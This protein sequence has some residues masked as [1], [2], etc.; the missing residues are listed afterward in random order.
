MFIRVHPAFIPFWRD[1]PWLEVGR[2]AGA[3][4]LGT[5]TSKSETFNIQLSTF[6]FQCGQDKTADL[7]GGG[8]KT[9]TG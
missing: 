5:R 2:V 9:L 7:A 3:P 8:L 1:R 6:N 4:D